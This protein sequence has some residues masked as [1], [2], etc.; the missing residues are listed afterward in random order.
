MSKN[1]GYIVNTTKK[2]YLTAMA[3]LNINSEEGTGDWH[4]SASFYPRFGINPNQQIAGK[5]LLQKMYVIIDMLKPVF[6]HTEWET[7]EEWKKM[8]S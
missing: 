5:E 7:V 4:F 3:T 6:N 1:I 2:H 8:T